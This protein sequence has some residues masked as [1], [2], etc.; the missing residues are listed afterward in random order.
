MGGKV[1]GTGNYND[2]PY[3]MT[4]DLS[5]NIYVTGRSANVG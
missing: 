1:N 4:V 5:G 2:V 3:T